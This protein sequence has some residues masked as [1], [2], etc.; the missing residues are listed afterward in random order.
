MQEIG[1]NCGLVCHKYCRFFRYMDTG[2]VF[3]LYLKSIIWAHSIAVI[4]IHGMDEFGV[5]LPVSPQNI[6]KIRPRWN[7][8]IGGAKSLV[9]LAY[10]HVIG[11]LKTRAGRALEVLMLRIRSG[12]A[13]RAL[14]G[15]LVFL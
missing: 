15:F 3:L 14:V 7:K 2:V 13:H 9:R 12:E 10:W 6:N 8:S 11:L 1:D 5:R 4:R